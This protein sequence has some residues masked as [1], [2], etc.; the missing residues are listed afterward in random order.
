MEKSSQVK[1]NSV[2]ELA[3]NVES[4]ESQYATNAS[5]G[6]NY[7]LQTLHLFTVNDLKSILVP[8][9]AFG[10]F[11]ALSGPLL[12]TNP[13]VSL[14]AV[15]SRLPHVALWTYLNLIV[16]DVANQRLLSSLVEDSVNKAWRPLPSRR[17]SLAQARRLLLLLIP[18]V[19]VICI[20]LGGLEETVVMHVLTWMYNDLYGADEHYAVRNLINAA[21]FMT[22]SYGAT[23]VAIGSYELNDVMRYQWVPIVGAVVLTTLQMQDMSDQEGDAHKGR[24]TLP[25]RWGDGPARWSIAVPVVFWSLACPAFWRMEYWGW[26]API[27]LGVLLAGRV[28][29]LRN[30]GQD[31]ITWKIWCIWTMVLYVLP[32]CKDHS[33]LLK[34]F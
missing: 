7:H 5:R 21:G 32:L 12:T 34:A 27:L 23:R 26:P 16:F 31:K 11:S 33:V 13:S 30:V 1:E 20:F 19:T 17:L 29:T 28:L 14:I 15:I 2:E 3:K 8:E 18:V 6:L 10:I 9:T 25:L 24:G 22:Y 4:A